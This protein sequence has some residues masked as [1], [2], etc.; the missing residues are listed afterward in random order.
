[1]M[2]SALYLYAGCWQAMPEER[3]AQL[4]NFLENVLENVAL[5]GGLLVAAGWGA[6]T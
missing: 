3:G 1:M 4:A 5:I 6:Q 2:T